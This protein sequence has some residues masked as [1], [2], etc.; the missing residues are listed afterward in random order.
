[1]PDSRRTK[2][3]ERLVAVSVL[4]LMAML[5]LCDIGGVAKENDSET[6]PERYDL[7]ELGLVTD[8]KLQG[9]Q[10]MCATFACVAAMESNALVRGYG[11]NDISE[12]QVG[13]ISD[14][15]V[16]DDKSLI[17]GEGVEAH[18]GWWFNGTWPDFVVGA[19]MRG[20]AL[21]SE[22]E[23][24][25][26]QVR[27]ELPKEGITF[28]GNLFIDSCYCALITDT[29]SVKRLIMKNGAVFAVAAVACWGYPKVGDVD[30]GVAYLPKYTNLSSSANHGVAIVGWDDN[31]S[32]DNFGITPP[33]DGAWIVKSSFGI[34]RYG[35]NG[36]WHISYYDAAF[37]DKQNVMSITV[38]DNREYDRIYQYDG[39]P[40]VCYLE[41]VTDAVINFTAEENE[42]ITG[43]RI[44]PTNAT[45]TRLEGMTVWEF[46][47]T[48]AHIKVYRGTFSGDVN[49]EDKPIYEQDYEIE[50]SGYQTVMLDKV[51]KLRE[52]QPYYIRVTFDDPITYAM[53][54]ARTLG[55]LSI[56][57]DAN[58]GET[59]IKA[60]DE[61][62]KGVWYDGIK[63][64]Q[65]NPVCSVC[66]KVLAR[67]RE[68]SRLEVACIYVEDH[69]LMCGA[70]L[71]LI[72]A[73]AIAAIII[74]RRGSANKVK[75][76]G[77]KDADI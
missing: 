59:Y 12:Y 57:A 13:Y 69:K 7:R 65:G 77:K 62:E 33:G 64:P 39:G 60:L 54:G 1:M 42:E 20:Y 8:A 25:F 35:D 43:V 17:N 3:T 58:P 55:G 41:G 76:T 40:G 15:V 29:E 70:V 22:E 19:F 67:D 34:K 30:T 16:T 63:T 44:K 36:Y 56:I 9:K 52:D 31:Y 24:P 73:A 11:E 6:I 38:V 4:V 18:A 23:F 68:L 74:R 10:N 48:T 49:E 66:L 37:R 51:I 14:C 26:S 45:I 47:G 28:D 46:E 72:V 71:A 27:E 2:M 75:A 53:D 21:K 5:L 32:K 50:Y 61:E